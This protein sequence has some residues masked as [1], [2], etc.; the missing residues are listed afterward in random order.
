MKRILWRI[1]R[2]SG[3]WSDWYEYVTTYNI[4]E[5]T[6]K[7]IS[8][9][10]PISNGGTGATTVADALANL[11]LTDLV[12]SGAKIATGSYVGAGVY[13]TTNASG[14]TSASK[15]TLTFD[16]TPKLVIINWNGSVSECCCATFV[17]GGSY[18]YWVGND[19]MHRILY[20]IDGSTLIYTSSSAAG[21]LNTSGTTYYYVAIG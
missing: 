8:D 5:Q 11:G 3:E 20:S 18:A 14:L 12:A 4:G 2:D 13:G 19:D 10:L 6:A 17:Y 1:R 9:T 7:T 16:F 21:Q 15:N